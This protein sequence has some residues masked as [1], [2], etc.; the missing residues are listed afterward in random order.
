[1]DKLL[2][3]SRKEVSGRHHLKKLWPESELIHIGCPRILVQGKRHDKHWY[4]DAEPYCGVAGTTVMKKSFHVGEQ[5]DM[6]NGICYVGVRQHVP[7][8]LDFERPALA[9][10]DLGPNPCSSR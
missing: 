1:M 10:D 4:T 9:N 5:S 2:C 8:S 3:V 6:R 7:C